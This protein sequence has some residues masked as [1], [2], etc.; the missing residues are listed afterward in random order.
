MDYT[1]I[2][3]S[4]DDIEVVVTNS[5]DEWRDAVVIWEEMRMDVI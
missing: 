2:E 4:L 5:L 1:M 3:Q